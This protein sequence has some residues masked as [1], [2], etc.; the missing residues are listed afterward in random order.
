MAKAK[1]RKVSFGKKGGGKKGGRKGG[2]KGNKSQAWRAYTGSSA[3]IP[4]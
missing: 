2:G 1:V 4:D 3:P